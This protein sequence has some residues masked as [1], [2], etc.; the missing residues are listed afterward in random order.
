MSFNINELLRRYFERPIDT[1]GLKHLESD[2]WSRIVARKQEQPV[3]WFEQ[4][5]SVIFQPQ[6]RLAPVALAVVIGLSMGQMTSFNPLPDRPVA[7]SDA[8]NFEV[9]S[10]KPGYLLFS[11]INTKN[12]NT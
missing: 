11:N 10:S 2:V 7:A 9:F 12:R 6:Y 8:L 4:L 5:L 1:S 3:G